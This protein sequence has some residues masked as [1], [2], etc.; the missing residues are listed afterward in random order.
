MKREDTEID[1]SKKLIQKGPK[2]RSHTVIFDGSTAYLKPT[3]SALLFCVVYICVGLFL[4]ILATIVYTKNDKIDLAIFLGIFGVAIATFGF[5]LVRPFVKQVFFDKRTGKFK[6]NIHD[7]VKIEN[8]VSL[9]I[10][11][12]I[13]TSKYGLSYPCYELNLST[14]NDQR[15]N[16]LNHNDIAQLKNDAEKLAAF[17][18]VELID[19][20]HEIIL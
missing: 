5:T 4:L 18:S 12:K 3:I 1:T 14:K 11:N 17:L 20:Q 9:Q 2:F 6:N 15:V 8:I 19:L 16:I 13:I 7:T 10:L